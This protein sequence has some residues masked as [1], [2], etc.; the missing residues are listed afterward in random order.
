MRASWIVR[1]VRLMALLVLVMTGTVAWADP[2][3][4]EHAKQSLEHYSTLTVGVLAKGT[5]KTATIANGK[6]VGVSVDV[7]RELAGPHTS[8]DSRIY[9]DMASL[10]DAACNGEVDIVVDVTRVDDRNWCLTFTAPYLANSEARFAVPLGRTALRDDLNWRLAKLGPARIEELRAR[11]PQ[12]ASRLGEISDQAPV[13]NLSAD[14]RAYLRSL[15]PLVLGVDSTWAPF[16]YADSNGQTGGIA[17]AY[18]AYLSKA[19]D[20]DF[21]H[22]VYPDWAA[23]SN[24]FVSGRVDVIATTSRDTPRLAGGIV[25]GPVESYPLVMVAR[26]GEVAPASIGEAS[27]RRVVVTARLAASGRLGNLPS[28]TVFSVA[29]NLTAGLDRVVR[30]EADVFVGDLAAV[31]IALAARYEDQLR[32]IGPAGEFEHIGF[33]LR[34]EFRRLA[35][36][37]ERALIA[38]PAVDKQKILSARQA[39]FDPSSSGWSVSAMRLLPALIAIAVIL[40]VTLRAFVLLQREMAR[41]VDTE[42]RLATQ[43]SFQQ[44]MMEV[45]PYPLVAKDLE[46]RYIAVN[47]AFEETLGVRREN[48]IGRTTLEAQVWGVEDSKRLH[49]LIDQS[50]TNGQREQVEITFHDRRGALRHGLFWTGAF[51]AA[52]GAMAGAVGTMIDITDIRD[53][54]MRARENEL[55]LHDVTRSL[56]AVVFQLRRAVDGTYSFPYV[57]GD[58]RHLFGLD[59]STLSNDQVAG[60]S[61][62]HAEDKP[63]VR[64]AIERSALTLEPVHTEFRSIV[65]EGRRWIRADLV[66]HRE[67]DGAV[68]W[69][70]YWVDASIERARADELAAARDAAEAA[71]RA[72]DDFLAMMSHEIRTPMNGVLGLVEVFENTPLNPDQSQMLGMIQD[73]ASALLQILDDLLDYSK[74]EA[75]RLAIESMPIDLRELVDNAVGLLAGRAH[76]KGLRVRVAVAPDVAASLRGDSVRL[77]QVLFNLLSNAIKFTMKGEVTLSV[78]LV[79]STFGVQTVEL[80]VED[81]GIGIAA[82]AQASLFEPFVQAETSTTR[83]FGGTGL[84]LTI[85]NK[86]VELMGGT[87]ELK[88]ELGVGTRMT[89]RL[90]MPVETQSYQIDGLR[91]KRG[92]IAI[93]DPRVARA[94]VDYGQALGLD[95]TIYSRDDPA[96]RDPLTFSGIDLVFLSDAHEEALPLKTRVIHVTEKP[97]PTGYRILDDDIRVSVNPISWRGLGAACVAALTGLPQIVS[98]ATR[99]MDTHIEAP[100]RERAIRT[101]RLV[102]VAEDHPVN[103]EL[104]RHQLSLLGFACDIVPDGVEALAALKHGHYGFLITD[105]HMPNMTGYELARRVRASELGLSKRLPILGITASTAPEE[106]SMC[107]DAGMDDCFVKPTRLATLRDHLNRWRVMENASSAADADEIVKPDPDTAL[108]AAPAETDELDLGYMTQ[109]WGSEATVKALLDAFVSSFRDDLRTLRSLLDSGGSVAQL[110]EWH[111]RVIG[112][113]SVLQYRPLQLALDVF[114][115]DLLDKPAARRNE[116]GALLIA[117]CEMLLEII[118]GQCAAIA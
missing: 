103:Q 57:G 33:A 38:M 66:A 23:V 85:C 44:T 35:P 70:G 4:A 25:T 74:I 92:I 79:E 112:A 78:N 46:N 56:P 111:H 102:L 63:G 84:G 65:D 90:A 20:I 109:L 110:R 18:T 89:V 115:R 100:D 97:K 104:I 61:V 37:I 42:Q 11:W 93:D 53:A 34:P 54:E 2:L 91:G 22:R 48:I 83:R 1:V 43:L 82:D 55:R 52:N 7:L 14:E 95:L 86:L 3:R 26:Q 62:I 40:G 106:L 15:P 8:L 64:D 80:S 30:G 71:S 39:A 27:S 41:R 96:L 21:D 13:L 5:A 94:L 118:E 116:D 105:C 10:I 69:N 32:I 47:R 58:T 117:R 87:L 29:P 108:H 51:K 24:A 81:T 101:G 6:P 77:R 68:V 50:L 45:V 73:S 107:R 19:L 113:A 31:D 88:S 36:L 67:A 60:L 12:D 59:L 99:G 17:L 9:P 76:E 75:G 72:K 49:D 114:R 98:R 16:T 28:N